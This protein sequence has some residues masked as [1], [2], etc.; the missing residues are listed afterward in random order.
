[1]R[2]MDK[3]V[4]V[5]LVVGVLLSVAY[6]LQTPTFFERNLSHALPALFVL[7]ALGVR[8]V[9]ERM[10]RG[11]P[12]LGT[13]VAVILAVALAW[14]AARLTWSLVDE[15][16]RAARARLV[17]AFDAGLAKDS[18]LLVDAGHRIWQVDRFGP[19]ICGF[20]VFKVIDFGDRYAAGLLQSMVDSGR[21]E[22]I[23]R[24]DGPFH[25]APSS[26]L[27]TYHEADFVYLSL[28]AQEGPDCAIRF[29]PLRLTDVF[30]EIDVPLQLAG[31]AALDG[32]P[33]DMQD[34]N[35]VRPIYSTRSGS[36]QNV[37]EI[38]FGPFRACRE[39]MFPVVFG[40]QVEK[41]RLQVAQEAKS[42]WQSVYDGAIP[43]FREGRS[44]VRLPVPRG[45]CRS[46]RI[47]VADRGREW[48]QWV[49]AGEPVM[50]H[51]PP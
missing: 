23:R 43:Q 36:D 4:A 3:T 45:E 47:G 33:E 12:A 24:F 32:L 19:R 26:T 50:V 49:G 1:M 41:T 8:E 6:F 22:I 39:V 7:S 21:F 42:E 17:Q 5:T 10:A 28:V 35:W 51:A 31:A 37:G 27:Q 11:R 2:S 25:G 30:D 9:A 38:R 15:P 16:A 13:G 29:D 46:F 44:L 18:F 48:G 40:P 20:I 34:V 14:P